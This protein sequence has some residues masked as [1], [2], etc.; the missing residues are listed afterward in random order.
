[1]VTI[2]IVAAG[3]GSRFGSTVPK[4]F[5]PLA[6][7]PVVMRT[8]ES[9]RLA[10][11]AARLILVLSPSEEDR[12]HRLCDIYSF[13]SP[14]VCYGGETRWHS[15]KNAI[16]TIKNAAPDD[17]IMVHDGARPFVSMSLI[18]SIVGAMG[19]KNVDGAIPCVPVTDSLR[20]IEDKGTIAVDR[21]QYLAVQTPQAFCAMMLKKAYELPYQS[22]FT[23]DASVMEA[24]GFDNLAVCKG[25]VNNI[26]ITNPRDLTIAGALL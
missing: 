3:S 14:Q 13:D 9:L 4:Q 2:I 17:V 12:W 24:A 22:S 19:Q 16:D 25:D 8:I 21:S 6:G 11:P 10:L 1:M 18:Q 23:D 20:H 5:L 15:V 26:K 7:R